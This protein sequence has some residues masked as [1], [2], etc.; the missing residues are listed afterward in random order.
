MRNRGTA[1]A[2][3]SLIPGRRL[4]L[5][6][7]ALVR[8]TGW[9]GQGQM[10]SLLGV[11]CEGGMLGSKGPE[12]Q[13]PYTGSIGGNGRSGAGVGAACILAREW[14]RCQRMERHRWIGSGGSRLT[15]P[16]PCAL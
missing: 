1:V 7:S 9:P 4:G 3:G 10:R 15:G 8:L 6:I 12:W 13:T 11:G 5:G 16:S 2:K 14:Q